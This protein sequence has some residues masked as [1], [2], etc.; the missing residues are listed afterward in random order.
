M[1]SIRTKL[2]VGFGRILI[3]VEMDSCKDVVEVI[4]PDMSY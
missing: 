1:F 4:R 3:G 2:V